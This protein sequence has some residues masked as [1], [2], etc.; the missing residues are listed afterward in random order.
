MTYNDLRR[1]ETKTVKA[2]LKRAGFKVK[3][4]GHGRGTAWGWLDVQLAEPYTRDRDQEAVKVVQLA[5][6]R[7][8]PEEYDGNIS[9]SME[10]AQ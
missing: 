7:R 10:V 3:H 1:E 8:T 4:V 6:G 9:L 2:A 5:T